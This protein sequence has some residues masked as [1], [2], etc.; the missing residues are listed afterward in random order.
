VKPMF[1]RCEICGG[2]AHPAC[3]QLSGREDLQLCFACA[4]R[5]APTCGFV[6]A[7]APAASVAAP[8]AT[9]KAIAAMAALWRFAA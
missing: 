8:S 6:T 9:A 5:M 4:T 7:K 3:A 1:L 2:S